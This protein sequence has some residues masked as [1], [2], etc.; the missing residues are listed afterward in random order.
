MAI[1]PTELAGEQE[2]RQR[3]ALAGAPTEFAKGPEREG[4]EVAG[5]GRLLDV[6]GSVGKTVTPPLPGTAT[7]PRALKPKE[8]LRAQKGVSQP[9]GRVAQ[10]L[11]TP[12]EA[13][14]VPDPEQFSETATKR[15]LAAQVLSPE[16]VAEFER[17]GLQTFKPG[18]EFPTNVL[19][20]AQQAI[21]A[22]K[23]EADALAID[24]NDVAQKALKAE[25]RG[26]KPETGVADEA[27]ADDVLDRLSVK[28]KNIK[29]LKDGGD[30]NFDYLDTDEDVQAVITAIGE[31]YADETV[32]RTRGKI[33]NDMSLIQARK[34]LAN[35]IGFTE[36]LL[37]RKIGDR[38][39]VA[40]EF[41][42]ARELLVRSA[43]KLEDLARRIKTGKADAGD[44][45]KFRRQLAIHSGI[46]L[47]LKGA[48]T[49]A[50]RA[51][52]SFQVR[53]D[54]ELDATRFSEEAQRL[55]QETGGEGVTDA[56]ADRLLKAGK[57]NGLKGINEFASGGWWAKTKQV[58]HEAY[59]A[60]LLSSPAT[61]VKNVVGGAS[62]MLYQLPAE[63]I[64]GFYGMGVRGLRTAAG[65]K[66]LISEDQIYAQD[67]L[68]RVKGWAD[69]YRDALKAASIAWRTEMPAG[70]SKLDV[71][72]YGVV[73]GQGETM[74]GK[75]LTEIGKRMRIPFRL[76]LSA[77]EFVKTISQRGELYTSINR[78]YQY[79][80]R[81]GKTEQEALDEAG[82][83]LLDPKAMAEDL[84]YKAKFDTLQTDLGMFGKV[85]G[86]LQ[87]TMVGRFIIP[88]VTAP[89]NSL[90]RAMEYTPFS[91]SS[92]DLLGLNGSKAQQ[93]AVGRLSVG[94]ATMYTVSQYAM[95]GQMTGGL[96]QDQ[97]A[98]EALP[99]GWQ[100]YSFVIRGEG[101][102]EDKP[103]YNP[104]G[105]PNGPLTYI[106]YSGFEPVGAI[107]GVTA[108]AVQ[109][110]NMTNDPE[111]QQNYWHAALIA[112]LE[113]YKELPMLQGVADIVSF[114]DG[115]DPAKL[116]RSYAES[117]TPI[118]LPNPLSSLQRMFQ[119]IADPTKVRPRDDVEYYTVEDVEK[120][121]EDADGNKQFQFARKD[122]T[123]DYRVVGLPKSNVGDNII[124]TFQ[125][126]NSL[127][128]KDSFFRD[129]RDYNAVQYDTFGEVKGSDEFSF[130]N[131]P[132]AAILGN[133]SGLRLKEGKDLQGYEREMI[134]LYTM[135]N[136]WPVN[137]PNR[138][139]GLKLSYGAQSDLTNLAKNE[140]TLSRSG[141]G[142]MDFRTT[143]EAI[144]SS[145]QYQGLTDNERISMLSAINQE[146]LQAGFAA[147]IEMPG[148]ENMRTAYEQIEILKEEGRR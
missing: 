58:V 145:R 40:S 133:L 113:Y 65:E 7:T 4:F 30:F 100:P 1:D 115:F 92:T 64:S 67:A 121:I 146:F 111:L 9:T 56:M 147:L 132:G 90:L 57:K 135:T 76:L 136:K 18:E 44:R 29:S 78:R 36:E 141:F 2:A 10:R 53:I 75:S 22:E 144:T 86:Q 6:L 106:N 96:P 104:F 62:F 108:D 70:K 97:K 47:Q 87:R 46:Q 54:G 24:V 11:P 131:R 120:I 13:G 134:R 79:A 26:F 137:N 109:R 122:G 83:V 148:Y 50:A 31:V 72:Q 99:P 95:N 28:E 91:K 77:D 42:A 127:Q 23:A 41:L 130:A 88:F 66:T 19:E 27:V 128:A 101:F 138:Y 43:T 3:T 12:Q 105:V 89:T 142:P 98:R 93:L 125:F 60:G 37:A 5:L 69:S 14:V 16:G 116:A 25:T 129:E 45:L 80:L 118:G 68:L 15:A 8:L 82:M 51:L 103:L 110:A 17:R 61:Q 102:P 84:D 38:P 107:L 126:M 32:A 85:A 71:E 119:R 63:V 34:V 123:P 140:I 21:D 20:D 48:Q 139:K 49:E 124:S 143:L 33:P 59:L 94:S 73:A 112:T 52:Q 81:Q 117:S 114:M 39:L 55:L 35:E 74:F